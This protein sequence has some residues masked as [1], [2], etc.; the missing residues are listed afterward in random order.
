MIT[1]AEFWMGRDVTFAD[2]LTPSIR[3]NAVITVARVNQLLQRAE[4]LTQVTSGWRPPQIN[5]QT[6][7][8]ARLSKHMAG[9]ACDLSDK[10]GLLDAWCMRNL[11]VLADIGLWLEHPDSTPNWCHL[12][13]VAPGSGRRV[14]HP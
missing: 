13:I 11:Q 5:G 8:A 10:A 7:G 6:K 14:F 4:V 3:N 9:Q 2:E 12:Q 1:I